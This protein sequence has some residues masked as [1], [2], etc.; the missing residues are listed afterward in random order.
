MPFRM[1]LFSPYTKTFFSGQQ[2]L[3]V[4]TLTGEMLRAERWIL[5]IHLT[6]ATLYDSS[7]VHMCA[8][9][10]DMWLQL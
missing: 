6:L 10:G 7:I 1:R 3:A 9:N 4:L 2:S 5:S 8:G